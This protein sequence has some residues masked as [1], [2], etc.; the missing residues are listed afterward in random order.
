MFQLGHVLCLGL[1]DQ[2][3][4]LYLRRVLLQ[5]V[6]QYVEVADVHPGIVVAVS[7]EKLC[8]QVSCMAR[9]FVKT[10]KYLITGMVFLTKK[11]KNSKT[12]IIRKVIGSEK[13]V[14][15][16]GI[17]PPISSTTKNTPE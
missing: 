8:N 7:V 15:R 11:K 17:E 5:A 14:R 4:D 2:H 12:T 16:A 6:H 3:N 1:V 10:L 9:N 13:K